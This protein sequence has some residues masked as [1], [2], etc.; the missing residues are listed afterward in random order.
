MK[1]LLINGKVDTLST[2]TMAVSGWEDINYLKRKCPELKVKEFSSP[3]VYMI[4]PRLDKALPFS[5]IKVRYA[6]NMA[7]NKQELVDDYY[8]GHAELLAWPYPNLPVFKRIYTPLKAQPQIVQDLFGYDINRARE[9][10][11]EAGYPDGF[12]FTLYSYADQYD[13]LLLIKEYLKAININMDLE[14][15]NNWMGGSYEEATYG[16]DYLLKPQEMMSMVKG[17]Q[18]NYS[19]VNDVRIQ[20]AYSQVSRYI[21]R[22]DTMVTRILKEICP[23]ELELAVPIYLP[24]GH[25]YVM[26][27]PWLQNFYGAI[28]GGGNDNPDEYLAYFWIDSD[29]KAVI[30]H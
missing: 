10:M 17:S 18:S 13:F 23:Y 15:M 7:V 2:G 4:W 22:D 6:M 14:I 3:S 12:S 11:T 16:S 9:L 21:G 24:L 29:M 20:E 28:G 1:T 25:S 26:W 5:D 19:R 30:G 27:Q 8:F